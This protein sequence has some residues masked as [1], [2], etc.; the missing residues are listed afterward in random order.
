MPKRVIRKQDKPRT[1]A[2]FV[3]LL[4]SLKDNKTYVLEWKEQKKQRSLNA[5]AYAWVLID[6]LAEKLKLTK[7]DVYRNAVSHMGGNGVLMELINESADRAIEIWES[8]GLGWSAKLLLK[9]EI[10]SQYWFTYGS[11]KFDTAQ[12]STLIELLQQDCAALGIET[13]TP[14]EVADMLSLWEQERAR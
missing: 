5:N 1:I 12:M 11:S 4:D 3:S 9:G 10:K 6:R 13:K 14:D 8:F 2:W 7:E